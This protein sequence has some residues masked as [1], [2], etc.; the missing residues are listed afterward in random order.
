[1]FGES[2]GKV[3]CGVL[4]IVTPRFVFTE[5]WVAPPHFK[6]K[7]LRVSSFR[8]FGDEL[9]PPSQSVTR[10]EDGIKII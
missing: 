3:M 1:M 4:G 2:N 7:Y 8:V 10:K 6:L 9:V 5:N